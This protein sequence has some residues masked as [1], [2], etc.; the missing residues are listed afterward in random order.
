[1]VKCPICSSSNPHEA[2]FCGSCGI[3]LGPQGELSPRTERRRAFAPLDLGGLLEETF[4]VYR[5]NFRSF[6]LIA[7]FPQIPLFLFSVLPELESWAFIV[8]VFAVF[9]LLYFLAAAATVRA[10]AL[11]Y[12]ERPIDVADCY[13]KAWFKV[14]SLVVSN[15]AFGLALFGAAVTIVGIPLFFYLAVVWY[16]FI[17]CIIVEKTGPMAAMW[18]SRDLVRG[19]YWRVLG[20]GAAYTV[21]FLTLSIVSLLI[22]S[23]FVQ[24]ST[25]L[26]GLAGVGLSAVAAPIIWIGKTLVYFDLRVRKENYTID[27]LAG[28]IGL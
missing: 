4:A 17:E 23:L 28:E 20:I 14:I 1:L 16:F 21:L 13:G 7:L 8:S 22:T 9:L 6:V 2:R 25:I 3:P 10:V 12:T 26:G 5:R 18:R 27:R 11:Q 24:A 19:S 15:M